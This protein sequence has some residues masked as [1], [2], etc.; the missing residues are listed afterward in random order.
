MFAAAPVAKGELVLEEAPALR[1][2]WV[3]EFEDFWQSGGDV[4]IMLEAQLRETIDE[5]GQDERRGFWGLHDHYAS[6]SACGVFLTN[7][8]PV[9]EDSEAAAL[10]LLGSRFNHSCVP[11]VNHTWQDDLEVYAFRAMRDIEAGEELTICYATDILFSPA[12]ERQ[13]ETEERFRFRCEGCAACSRG[14]DEREES[15]RRR[16]EMRR[17]D[18]KVKQTLSMQDEGGP[19]LEVAGGKRAGDP[20]F[21]AAQQ[22]VEALVSLLD[23]E[24]EGNPWMK[25]LAFY[26]GSEIAFAAG[27]AEKAE[28][29]LRAAY[30]Q[31]LLAE[32]EDSD[33]SQG[34][35]ETLERFAEMRG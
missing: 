22:A 21:A 15:D 8:L 25:S 5:L 10:C 23:E 35:K 31:C 24:L 6:G 29:L 34:I 16:G 13:D 27:D 2:P 18:E 20:R 17:L 30:E 7:A 14:P 33:M 3:E 19:R 26:D 1:F 11:N 32:G 9:G 12:E 28:I 4:P